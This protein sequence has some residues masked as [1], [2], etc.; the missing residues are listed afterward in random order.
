[1]AVEEPRKFHFSGKPLESYRRQIDNLIL[2]SQDLTSL[3]YH[4]SLMEISKDSKV[5]STVALALRILFF[6]G[7][8]LILE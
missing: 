1:V 3:I 4:Q 7:I 5:K 8:K 2:D 6:T